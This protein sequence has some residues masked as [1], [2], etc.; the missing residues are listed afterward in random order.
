MAEDESAYFGA[1]DFDDES[2]REGNFLNLEFMVFEL[3]WL[4]VL[5]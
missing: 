4:H 3:K 1:E 2:N 5:G